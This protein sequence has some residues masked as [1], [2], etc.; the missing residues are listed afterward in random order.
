MVFNKPTF[1]F[2]ICNNK[3]LKSLTIENSNLVTLESIEMI[4]TLE[5]LSIKNSPQLINASEYIKKC[6]TLKILSFNNCPKISSNDKG[7][8]SDICTELKIKLT[9]N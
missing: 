6:K 3:C 5:E 4:E 1:D 2:E 9:I 8:L 7:Q